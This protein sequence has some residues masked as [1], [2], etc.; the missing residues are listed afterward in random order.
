MDLGHALRQ[1]QERLDVVIQQI[2]RTRQ[3]GEEEGTRR[4]SRSP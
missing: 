2:A 1:G 4:T 3:R